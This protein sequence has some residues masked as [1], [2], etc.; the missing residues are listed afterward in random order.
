MGSGVTTEPNLGRRLKNYGPTPLLPLWAFMAYFRV[1]LIAFN[2]F[3]NVQSTE[4]VTDV[5]L[6]PRNTNSEQRTTKCVTGETRTPLTKR[7]IV[8][9]VQW[10]YKILVHRGFRL[11]F[12][13][14][15]FGKTHMH[16]LNTLLSI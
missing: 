5:Y 3:R 16:Q 8:Y 4:A 6:V 11:H 15:C 2:A 14:L 12:Q 10:A 9:V 13:I 1:N 7:V